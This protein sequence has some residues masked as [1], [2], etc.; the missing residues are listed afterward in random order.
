MHFHYL[1]NT[2]RINDGNKIV[3]VCVCVWAKKSYW[4]RNILIFN[5]FFFGFFEDMTPTP[6]I[7][8]RK[9]KYHFINQDK[10][11]ACCVNGNDVLDPKPCVT[12]SYHLIKTLVA[13]HLFFFAYVPTV[14]VWKKKSSSSSSSSSCRSAGTYFLLSHVIRIYYPSLLAG[15]LD[16]ILCLHRAL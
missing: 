7:K 13:A 9:R 11:R 14:T 4:V 12:S 5:F 6:T 15:L 3:C 10:S 2:F 16:D 8:E 1:I